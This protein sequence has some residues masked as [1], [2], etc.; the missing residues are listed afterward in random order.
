ML[1]IEFDDFY[2]NTDHEVHIIYINGIS[3]ICNITNSCVEILNKPTIANILQYSLDELKIYLSEIS[4]E[5]ETF[6]IN[7]NCLKSKIKFTLCNY[8]DFRLFS[9]EKIVA[10]IQS[11]ENFHPVVFNAIDFSFEIE[12]VDT[13]RILKNELYG[14]IESIKFIL[15]NAEND[16]LKIGQRDGLTSF[17]NF[18]PKIKA[19][20]RQYL[21]YFSQF[22]EDMG[23][24]NEIELESDNQNRTIFKVFPKDKNTSLRAIAD[25]LICYL[26][27]AESQTT[28]FPKTTEYDPVILQLQA[29]VSHLQSQLIMAQS[30][31]Q[32][33]ESA[34]Q[35]KD[36]AIEILQLSNFQF[37]QIIEKDGQRETEDI[38]PGVLSV[39]KIEKGGV[40]INLGEVL[41]RLKRLFVK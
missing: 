2:V 10:A 18:P 4:F 27:F 24:E 12:K 36:A 17:F 41:K 35:A 30:I 14:F 8:D 1:E 15:K 6:R 38:I 33:K 39:G 40:T 21:V 29:N 13:G 34:L 9:V 3:G 16:V 32:M 7:I 5:L 37:R 19:A 31:I 25:A 28:D 22:L 20:C 26:K 23:V 11:T